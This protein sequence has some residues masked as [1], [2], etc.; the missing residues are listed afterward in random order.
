VNPLTAA[1]EGGVPL[2]VLSPHLDDAVL[3]CGALMIHA[4][5]RTSVTVATL[6]TE[7]RPPPYTLSARRH[8][9]QVGARDAEALHRQRQIED[10]AAL[11]PMGITCIHAGLTEALFR[12]RPHPGGRR[13]WAC[14][15]PELAHV[16][17]VYR[18]H[19]ISGRIAEADAATLDRARDVIQRLA[20]AGP[21]LVLV[22]LGVGGHVDHALVRTAAERSGAN[23]I[24]YS[25]FP[26][27]QRHPA[28]PALIQGK[29]LVEAQWSRHLE[30]KAE[31]VRAY[32]SQAHALFPG[33][34]I[35]LVPEVFLFE[36]PLAPG[37]NS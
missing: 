15:L 27:N 35:P 7:A 13:R 5:R 8:L 29:R 6:F 30:A 36:G 25:D 34:R 19:I 18:R 9:H 24:Y 28:D 16:Y 3:S 37:R 14:P 12:L 32:R 22:P 4:C 23:I 1:I 10:R 2:I 21:N 11:E 26:Y 33:G 17:P 20:L 31:L